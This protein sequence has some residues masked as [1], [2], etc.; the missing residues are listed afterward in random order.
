MLTNSFAFSGYS[1]TDL[2]AALRFYRDVLGL[3]VS[4]KPEG[5]QLD[6]KG[7]TVFLYQKKDHVPATF[8]VLNFT[9]ADID[10]TVDEMIANGVTF[11]RY[12]I[13]TMQGDEKNIYRGLASGNGPDIAWFK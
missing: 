12:D 2:S 10:A 7:S 1:V 8:T 4:E 13:G 6:L 9:V 5:I 3:P 11:D